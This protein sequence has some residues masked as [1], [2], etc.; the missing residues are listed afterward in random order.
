MKT[1]TTSTYE[2][3]ATNFLSKH[4]IGFDYRRGTKKADWEPAGNHYIIYL[5][6]G[7]QPEGT[8]KRL[9]FDFWGSQNDKA[10]GRSPTAYDVLA[11]ISGEVNCPDGFE[12][13]CA[14]YGYNTDSRKVEATWAKCVE[15]ARKASAFFTAEEIKNLA[16]ID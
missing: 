15:F 5:D 12:D 11:C 4:S 2:Q 7:F 6:K 8:Q 9:Q 16:E 10:A 3:Q 14:E 13:F 1:D